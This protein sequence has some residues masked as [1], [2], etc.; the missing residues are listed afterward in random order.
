MLSSHL[1]ERTRGRFSGMTAARNTIVRIIGG[2][3]RAADALV[4]PWSC[5]LCEE[6]GSNGPFCTACRQELLAQAARASLL[7]CPRCAHPVGPFADLRGGCAACRGQ[8]LGFD[9]AIAFG[10]YTGAIQTL[11]LQLKH[12]E[13]A[14]LVPWLGKLF[15]EARHEAM[16]QL[17]SDTWVVAV[18]LYWL[19]ELCRGY[20]QSEALARSLGRQLGLPVRQPIR[21]VLPTRRLAAMGPTARHDE[22]RKAFR[23]RRR[24]GL[25]GRTVLLVD[26]VLTTGATSGAAARILKQA[27]AARVIVTVIG[28]TERT[29][30]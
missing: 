5:P 26:D 4:F 17:P 30:L 2:I 15:M 19:R 7:A 20:N 18:P 16:A 8:S 12:E 9:A 21:R 27:G 14:W 25:C 29:T 23:A 13:N 24:A 3:G 22:M 1:G 10:P 6:S 28:R 11:C